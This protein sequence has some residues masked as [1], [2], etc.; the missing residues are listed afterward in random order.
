MMTEQSEE[1]R[2]SVDFSREIDETRAIL[3]DIMKAHPLFTGA[4]SL[5]GLLGFGT[6]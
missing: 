2:G 3:L 5:L 1:H 4:P 6:V